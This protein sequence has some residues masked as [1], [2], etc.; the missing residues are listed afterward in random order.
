MLKQN[1]HHFADDN[2]IQ[3]YW[4]IYTSLPFNKLSSGATHIRQ[5]LM[6]WLILLAPWCLWYHIVPYIMLKSLNTLRLRSNGRHF[7]DN[8]FKCIFVNENVGILLKISLKFVPGVRIS[9]IP[10]L[11]QIMA[12]R[13][14]GD[15]PLSEPMMVSLLMHMFADACVTQPQWVKHSMW[16]N[17]WVS[18]EQ[19][20]FAYKPLNFLSYNKSVIALSCKIFT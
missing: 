3:V 5:R 2:D 17:W 20:R 7:A 4:S 13:R 16:S 18:I 19:L 1:G 8:I 15:K 11:V 9:N 6:H 10:A 12:W 14:S